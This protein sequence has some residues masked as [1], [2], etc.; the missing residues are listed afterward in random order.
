MS[1]REQMKKPVVQ[2]PLDRH[3][4][5]TCHIAADHE[6]MKRNAIMYGKLQSNASR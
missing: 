4:R 1:L 5:I 3:F 6:E 2:S